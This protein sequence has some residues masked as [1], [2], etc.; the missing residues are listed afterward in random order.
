MTPAAP[1]HAC[2]ITASCSQ[3]PGR[4]SFAQ[5]QRQPPH[6]EG[7]THSE[8]AFQKCVLSV[9]CTVYA[10]LHY[11]SIYRGF[12]MSSSSMSIPDDGPC[13]ART[14]PAQPD[15]QGGSALVAH[16]RRYFGLG[17]LV[18]PSSST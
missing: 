1:G 12:T 6:P 17:R 15:H 3:M 5:R 7:W 18:V 8:R 4:R 10:H 14:V 13:A 11:V 2:A 9:K 16:S